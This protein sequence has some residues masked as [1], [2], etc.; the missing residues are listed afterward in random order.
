MGDKI[1]K[2]TID[3]NSINGISEKSFNKLSDEQ[4]NIVLSGNNETQN[5]NKEGGLLGRLL[6]ANT[7][8]ASVHIAFVVCFMLLFF[9]GADLFH[10]FC[11]NNTLSSE[12]WDKVFPVITLALGYVFGKGEE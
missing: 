10:S 11:E 5:K 8:N 9:C 12:V 3:A 1:N 6:G 7:K 4:K 2:N